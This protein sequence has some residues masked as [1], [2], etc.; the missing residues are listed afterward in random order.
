VPCHT[1]SGFNTR[2]R[3]TQKVGG[4][5]TGGGGQRRGGPVN[6]ER[7]GWVRERVSSALALSRGSWQGEAKERPTERGQDRLG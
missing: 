1:N 5:N 2:G 6:T 4:V 3:D 7:G